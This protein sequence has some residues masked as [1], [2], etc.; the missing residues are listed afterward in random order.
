MS[1]YLGYTHAAPRPTLPYRL[2]YSP[3]LSDQQ[4]RQISKLL[5]LVL[6]HQPEHIGITLD[7]KGWTDVDILL[8]QLQLQGITL[9]RDQLRTLVDTSD[10]KRVALSADE[11]SI[12]ANQ[13]HSVTVDLGY[14]AQTPPPVLYHGT[15][16]RFEAAIRATGLAKM[17]RQ[18]VHL[19]A[20]PETALA[21]GRRHGKPVVLGVDAAAMAADGYTFFRSAN[22][23]WLTDAVPPAYLLAD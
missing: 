18:H 23:V 13:G 20:D 2:T 1:M 16:T 6:R 9:T 14:R 5:S 22:G 8:T 17:D 15:A 3:M 11:R 19:S 21:V 10:K 7:D 12:R 4:S